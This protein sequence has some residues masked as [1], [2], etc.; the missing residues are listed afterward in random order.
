MAMCRDDDRGVQS[1]G[2]LRQDEGH[3]RDMVAPHAKGSSTDPCSSCEGCRVA[4]AVCSNS[5]LR[6]VFLTA[7]QRLE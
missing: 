4:L 3:M 1:E 6:G 5:A 7:L 2:A